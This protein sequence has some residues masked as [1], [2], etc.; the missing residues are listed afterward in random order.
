MRFTHS[1]T[2]VADRLAIDSPSDIYDVVMENI[3]AIAEL[4]KPETSLGILSS[5]V[6]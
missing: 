2:H 3:V 5:G 6:Q 4:A 1:P